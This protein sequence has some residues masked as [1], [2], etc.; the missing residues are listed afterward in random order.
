MARRPSISLLYFLVAGLLIDII[1]TD[2]VDI[3]LFQNG[4][5]E[6][7]VIREMTQEIPTFL[8]DIVN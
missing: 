7:G 3:V 4:T 2:F 5:P 1:Q 8:D 6:I